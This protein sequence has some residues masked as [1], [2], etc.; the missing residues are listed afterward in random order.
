MK[1]TETIILIADE[2]FAEYEKK[3]MYPLN[4]ERNP[5][6]LKLTYEHV[7]ALEHAALFILPE[8]D[9]SPHQRYR[10][11]LE[12]DIEKL[13]ELKKHVLFCLYHQNNLFADSD[14]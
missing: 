11:K 14:T 8:I 1:Q 9:K 4:L 5:T 12:D 6:M 10:R 2:D 3:R 13:E 7:K